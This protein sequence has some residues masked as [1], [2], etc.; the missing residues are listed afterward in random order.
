MLPP[1]TLLADALPAVLLAPF[2]T[3]AVE[4]GLPDPTLAGDVLRGEY[5]DL[6][7]TNHPRD[8]LDAPVLE[9]VWRRRAER[10]TEE[11]RLLVDAVRAGEPVLFFPEGRPSPDGSIGPLRP[12]LK[13]LVRR[14]NPGTVRPIGLAYDPVTHGRPYAVFAMGRAILPPT[15]AIEQTV[16][17]H[18]RATTPLTCGQVVAVALRAAAAAGSERIGAADLDDRWRAE[19][20]EAREAERPFEHSLLD[21]S[22]RRRRLAGALEWALERG[23]VRREGGRAVVLEPG[24]ILC[25]RVLAYAAR[26]HESAREPVTE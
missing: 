9:P 16:L 5:A 17:A 7:W 26:E 19:I 12:G 21:A 4:L 6:L 14:G 24:A 1:G 18:L 13:L 22:C 15:G 3:R 2:R 25:D 20:E 11:L 8:V 23:L 10:A